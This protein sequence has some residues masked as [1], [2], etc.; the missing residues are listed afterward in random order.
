MC[1]NPLSYLSN[2]RHC[3]Y[4]FSGA[5]EPQKCYCLH[6]MHQGKGKKIAKGL[7]SENK[8]TQFVKIIVIVSV[9]PA[10]DSASYFATRKQKVFI[11]RSS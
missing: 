6:F 3:I 8:G 10:L 2:T 11:L 9:E 1:S 7:S 4:I 5:P